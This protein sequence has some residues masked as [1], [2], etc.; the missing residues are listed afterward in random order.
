MN[1]YGQSSS[2]G[3]NYV[4]QTLWYSIETG[5]DHNCGFK[6]G[7]HYECWGKNNHG[8][9]NIRKGVERNQVRQN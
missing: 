5:G 1:N 3:V 4:H 6:F 8:Q 9:L 2:P 7:G